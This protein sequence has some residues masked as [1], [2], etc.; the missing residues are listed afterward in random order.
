MTTGIPGP[1]AAIPPG[2]TSPEGAGQA[3][4]PDA[5]VLRPTSPGQLAWL[6]QQVAQWQAEGLVDDRQGAAILGRYRVSRRFSL[7]R[8]LLTLGATFVGVGLVWLVAAN[9]DQLSPAVRFA[10][11]AAL[12][13]AVLL[14]TELG[15]ATRAPAPVT[16]AARLLAALAFGAVVFQA[17]QS[18]QVP[19]YEPVLLG[20]W[21]LGCLAHAYAVRGD[22]PL[23]VGLATGTAWFLWWVLQDEPSAL[24]GVLAVAAA[25][26]LA[27]SVAALHERLA[28]W[29]AVPWREVGALLCLGALFAAALPWVDRT[30]YHAGLRLVVVLVAGG[31]ALVA[32]LAVAKGQA[33]L[34]PLGGLA[35]FVAALA[36]V[37]WSPGTSSDAPLHAVDVVHAA[38]S[39]VVYVLAAVLVAVLGT[40]RDSWRLTALATAGLVVFTTFQSFAVFARIVEGAWLFVLLGTVFVAT[41]LLFDR[42]RRELAATL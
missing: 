6:R 35:A 17:A 30:D 28:P 25:G 31:V 23:L 29:C 18:L 37:L 8:L 27:L 34:E 40:L 24:A 9:L 19:A 12:W 42:A 5:R 3:T 1:T 11:V 22:A 2:D 36:L 26:V 20:A 39:V 13:L 7:G 38:V 15:L 32:A 14:G 10:V 21:A 33:R 4:A 16:G 41:G